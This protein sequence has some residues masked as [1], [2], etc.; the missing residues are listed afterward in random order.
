[1][2]KW[3]HSVEIANLNGFQP[4]PDEQKLLALVRDVLEEAE[5]DLNE[6]CSLAAGAARTWGWFLQDVSSICPGVFFVWN[7]IYTYWYIH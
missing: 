6:S 4:N 5:C 7:R 2:T 3:I 1:M